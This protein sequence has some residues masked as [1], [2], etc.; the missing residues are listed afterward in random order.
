M[1]FTDP[2]ADGPAIQA[3]SLRALKAGHDASSDCSSW[4]RE[5]PRT[6]TTTTPIVLMGYYNPIHAYGVERFVD[7]AARGRRRR[8]DH[9]RS[10]AGGGRGAARAGAK[11]RA[12][13]SSASRRR[14]PTTSDCRRVLDGASGLSLLRLDRRR[15]RHQAR[16]RRTTSRRRSQ[17]IKR[18]TD[19]PV[20]VGFGIRTPEQA[21]AIARVAD[22]VRRR[23]GHRPADGRADRRRGHRPLVD[24]TKLVLELG[25]AD[26]PAR[27]AP[28]EHCDRRRPAKQRRPQA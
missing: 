24:C 26:S 13:T 9:R 19:L 12:S 21:A 8:P 7:D 4:S 11:A 6:A 27:S 23:F 3:S 15:D 18:H 28:R 22:A 10:A 25:R 5:L 20:A 17:R 16:R 2:M 1:P 14:P